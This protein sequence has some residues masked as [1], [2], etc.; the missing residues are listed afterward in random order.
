MA[1]RKVKIWLPKF[2]AQQ[3]LRL[4]TALQALGMKLPFDKTKAD[5][6]GISSIQPG[7]YISAVIHE[8]NCDVDEEGTVAA[9]ATA[10]VMKER[11]RAPMVNQPPV[12]RADHPFLFFIRDNE[13]G[14]ILFLG[15]IVKP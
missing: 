14:A 3:K 4:K 5:F 1:R 2:H 7:L 10:V 6:S 8:A 15:R 12:F 13:S 11:G 9:A